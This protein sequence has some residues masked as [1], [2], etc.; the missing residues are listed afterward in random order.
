M[1]TLSPNSRQFL[2]ADTL[3]FELDHP[4]VGTRGSNELEG[5]LQYPFPKFESTPSHRRRPECCRSPAAQQQAQQRDAAQA[6]AQQQAQQRDAAQ[7]A[8]QQ[9]AQQR[10]AAVGQQQAQA[11]SNCGHP[12][13]PACPR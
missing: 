1:S 3:G 5:A 11:H 8:A 7:A 6:A 13:Q 9:R 4:G 10:A 2:A 12:G